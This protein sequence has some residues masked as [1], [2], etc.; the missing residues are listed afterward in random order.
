MRRPSLPSWLR[1]IENDSATVLFQNT[2]QLFRHIILPC[3]EDHTEIAMQ[4]HRNDLVVVHKHLVHNLL[5][6]LL[7]RLRRVVHLLAAIP[8][9]AEVLDQIRR[10]VH[11]IIINRT[12]RY[13]QHFNWERPNQALTCHNQPPR[14]AF[15]T[16]P[17]LPA[18]PESVGPDRWL[19]A[20][21]GRRYRRQVTSRGT[22]QLDNRSYYVKQAFAAQYVTVRVD[23]AQRQLV[24]EHDKRPIK[25]IPIKGLYC[26]I[27]SFETY[28]DAIREEARLDWRQILQ[29]RQWRVAM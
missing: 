23:A 26:E 12:Q 19:A 17:Q 10:F 4:G 29:Q 16:L 1:V 24:I 20:I 28:F 25:Q 9:I 18:L 14:V 3:I 11:L 21:D 5:Q 27:L 15:P 2:C 7:A 6:K 22:I 13:R 8:I